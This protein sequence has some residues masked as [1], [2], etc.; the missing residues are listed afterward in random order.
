[1]KFIR[2]HL[3]AIL[4]A[5]LIIFLS[6][7]PGDEQP[8]LEILKFDKVIHLIEYGIFAYLVF[9]SIRQLKIS[10]RELII[11]LLTLL[12]ISLFSIGD[13]LFQRRIPGRT[14]DPLDIMADL[15]GAL[16]LVLILYVK[17]MKQYKNKQSDGK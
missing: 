9:R 8:K 7:I 10:D 5:A 15:L 2:Y 4:Y 3:P 6:S 11:G 14:S 17:S 16:I 12:F 13:E 1:M